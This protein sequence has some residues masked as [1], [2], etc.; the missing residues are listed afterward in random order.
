LIK[1]KFDMP[2]KKGKMTKKSAKEMI[3]PDN[4]RITIFCIN[5]RPG[6]SASRQPRSDRPDFSTAGWAAAGRLTTLVFG[7]SLPLPL[8]FQKMFG[9]YKT[10]FTLNMPKTQI[11]AHNF[12]PYNDNDELKDGYHFL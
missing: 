5:I 7:S 3:N 10:F 1:K 11:P 6:R 9:L 12:Y 4:K 8:F 2:V